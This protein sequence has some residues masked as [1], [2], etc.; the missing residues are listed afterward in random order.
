[1]RLVFIGAS[2]HGKVCGEIA[3]LSGKYDEILF[4]DKNKKLTECGAHPVVGEDYEQYVNEDTEFF[5][6]IGRADIRQRIQEELLGSGAKLATLI[7]PDSVVSRDCSLGV[8]CVV[9]AGAV[10]NAETNIGIGTIVN[11]CSSIDHDCRIGDYCHIAVG[12]HICGSVTIGNSSWIGAGA[13]VSNNLEISGN[14]MIGAGAVVVKDIKE[15]G[16]YV[17][18]PARAMQ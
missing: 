5:V 10:I 15:G 2:G 12:S 14:C 7:H 1:M 16:T 6:S 13:T 17:G 3:R 18:M 11:T 8:G 4:L 9:M